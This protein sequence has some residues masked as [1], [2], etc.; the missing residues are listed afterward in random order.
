RRGPAAT[1]TARARLPLGTPRQSDGL[2]HSHIRIVPRID[3]DATYDNEG[4]CNDKTPTFRSPSLQFPPPLELQSRPAEESTGEPFTQVKTFADMARRYHQ[5]D[6]EIEGEQST[7][8]CVSLAGIVKLQPNRKKATG[9]WRPKPASDLGKCKSL[10]GNLPDPIRLH[11]QTGEFDGQVVFIGHPNRDISAHQWSSTS[12]QWVNIGRYAHSR[13]K[14]EGSLASDRLKGYAASVAP[15]H[16]F[17]LAAEIRE[18][19]IVENGRT[20][21]D[22]AEVHRPNTINI[23]C[24]EPSSAASSLTSEVLSVF[25]SGTYG[26]FLEESKP[27]VPA[28]LDTTA[29]RPYLEDPFIA[30]IEPAPEIFPCHQPQ[31]DTRSL[32]PPPGLTVA[33]PHR[34]ISS[35]NASA[36]PYL[37]KLV[38]PVSEPSVSEATVVNAADLALKFSDPDGLRPMQEYEIANGLGQQ[39]PTTQSFKGPF[40]T[41][42]KPTTSDPTVLLSIHVSEEEKL[43]NWFR[44]GHRPA[45]QQEYAKTLISAAASNNRCRTFGVIGQG[46]DAQKGRRYK[47]TPPF[48]RL[49]EGLSEYAE[50]YRNGSGRSYFTR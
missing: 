25:E 12:F 31:N 30:S 18:K 2:T 15:L 14:V 5:K 48:V 8:G 20:K 1:H 50:E 32:F 23:A 4:N 45:R 16:F 42:T 24:K 10:F 44:D 43:I 38:A 17:R 33:N 3:T 26:P 49:Y 46:V 41:D 37:K 13:G 40:F 34:M 11:E 7:P 35:L 28:A 29:R 19:L 21:D 9:S 6:H 36:P 47:N 39:A 22:S 27:T